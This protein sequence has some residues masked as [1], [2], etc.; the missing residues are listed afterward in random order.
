[1]TLRPGFLHWGRVILHRPFFSDL[2]RPDLPELTVFAAPAVDRVMSHAGV[3]LRLALHASA[4]PGDR[5][6]P[7]RRDG[8]IAV[9]APVCPF[10]RWDKAPGELNSILN[11]VFDLFLDRSVA[12]PSACHAQ[13][14][15]EL[16]AWLRW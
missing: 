13:P 9:L 3:M 5:F 15:F 7:S 1:M 11:T 2:S 10:T 12:A 16:I 4:Y 14:T 8:L 6:A